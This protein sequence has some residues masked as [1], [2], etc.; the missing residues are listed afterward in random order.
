MLKISIFQ[1]EQ[2]F[3]HIKLISAC[4]FCLISAVHRNIRTFI[5]PNFHL[6]LLIFVI[7]NANFCLSFDCFHHFFIKKIIINPCFHYSINPTDISINKKLNVY[8]SF[9]LYVDFCNTIACCFEYGIMANFIRFYENYT[10]YFI[11]II[12]FSIQL[13]ILIFFL[14]Y[15]WFSLWL[16]LV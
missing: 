9:H 14:N 13:Y 6:S 11:C 4:S 7:S 3:L 2:T 16:I 5:K 12:K 8:W 15:W 1:Y 10:C